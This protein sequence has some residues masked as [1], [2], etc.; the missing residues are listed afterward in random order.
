MSG[1][2]LVFIAVASVL[3]VSAVNTVVLNR[4]HGWR[5]GEAFWF[6]GLIAL[7]VSYLGFG[8]SAWLGPLALSVANLGLLLAYLAMSL[9]LRYWQTS[10]TN[11]PIWLVSG[12]VLYMVV[13]EYLRATAPY[14][15]RLHLIHVTMSVITAYLFY[16]AVSY[17]R[18]NGSTQL[19]VLATTFA[20]EFLCAF[21]RFVLTVIQPASTNQQMT[22]YE[23]PI[24]M[25]ILR[26]IWLMANAMSYLTV[27]T[28]ELEKTLN[29]NETLRVLLKEK[30]LLLN[31]LSRH[32]RSD[33]SA[34]VGRT[35]SHELR[36]PLTTLL[37]ASKNL[38]AQLKSNDLTDLDMQVDFLCKECERSAN[39]VNQ[40]EEVFRPKR[41]H[42]PATNIA[43]A[44]DQAIKTMQPR[45]DADNVKVHLIGDFACTVPADTAQLE[46][47]FINLI[48][49][50]INALSNRSKDKQI[51][52]EAQTQ[53]LA[54]AITVRDNGSG[55]DP[56]VLPNLWQ[57][58]VSDEAKGS[59]IGLWLSQQ[60]VQ[61]HSGQIE[62][63]NTPDSGAWFRVVLPRKG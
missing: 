29:K 26:W 44:I 56:S 6:W 16:S 23:E 7:S 15:P 35:L 61:N 52:I 54:C 39:L 30:D 14:T 40:L 60:I 34:A 10:R 57:L 2:H 36:Q 53:P 33:K 25:V 59:G 27:M 9:Q 38:Q 49:N 1:D 4:E 45:L 28:F 17:Y 13:L 32:N 63:G 5:E 31:A 8:T 3:I 24:V 43:S 58:Y 19:M 37:L 62:A 47:V 50:S 51:T 20:I 41:A 46:T 18:K 11:V 48:S 55:I 12:A 22:L 42:M 21:S